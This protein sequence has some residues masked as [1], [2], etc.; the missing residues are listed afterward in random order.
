MTSKTRTPSLA[1]MSTIL[2]GAMILAGMLLMRF[3]QNNLAHAFTVPSDLSE[4]VRILAAGLLAAGSLLTS[5]AALES[6][7]E[8][9]R[10][11]KKMF[12]KLIGPAST[13]VAIWLAFLSSFGEEI[14]FRGAIQPSLG[15]LPTSI[16]FGLAHVGP[17]GKVGVWSF[18]ACGAGLVLG[19][20][21]RETNCLWPA[22]MGHFLVNSVSLLALQRQYR[23]R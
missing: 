20:T 12:I 13:W 10:S 9:F 11:L 19:W 15:L 17:D 21:F 18:W 4:R 22:I 8:S 6:W 1:R 16:L 2:Y 5:S 7:N 3:G 23:Q 14:L